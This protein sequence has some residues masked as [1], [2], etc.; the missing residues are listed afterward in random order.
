MGE[1]RVPP[2]PRRFKVFGAQGPADALL[3]EGGRVYRVVQEP[4]PVV[5]PQ[6]VVRV[7]GRYAYT[8]LFC[9]VCHG[10]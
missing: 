9:W 1:E 4:S 6:V 5:V 7:V 8:G 10:A 3:G 2:G